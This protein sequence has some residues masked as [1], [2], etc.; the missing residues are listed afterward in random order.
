MY[1]DMLMIWK[2]KINVEFGS[3]EVDAESSEEVVNI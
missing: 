1:S 2:A 3:E